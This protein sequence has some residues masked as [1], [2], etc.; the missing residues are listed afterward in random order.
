MAARILQL[1][2]DKTDPAVGEALWDTGVMTSVKIPGTYV[3]V[4]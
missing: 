1:V 4:G 2:I 3:I